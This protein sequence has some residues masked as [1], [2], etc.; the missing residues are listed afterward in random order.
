MPNSYFSWPS[1]PLAGWA[2]A[3]LGL[4][5][6]PAPAQHLSPQPAPAETQAPE[7][8][9]GPTARR[10]QGTTA[11]PYTTALALNVAGTYT[12]L[13][14]GGTVI[15]TPNNDDANS[16]PQEIGFPFSY[17]GTTFS[18][19]VLNTNGFIKLGEAAPAANALNVLL[20]TTDANVL[21]PAS[22]V[23]L[24]GAADQ[25]ANPTEFRVATTGAAGS[26]VCTIQF[27]N[28]R[29]KPTGTGT[30]AIPAQMS[31]MQFQIR[32]YEG[33][34]TID[35]V[36]GTWTATAN[37][38]TGQPFRIGLKGNALSNGTTP[39]AADLAELSLVAKPSLSAWSTATFANTTVSGT[40]TFP[41]SHFVR[42][43]VLPD[44][45]RTY[46]FRA[47]LPATDAAVATIH[48]LG[49]LAVPNSLP[50]TVVAAVTNRGTAA[51]TNLPVTLTVSGA[52][53]FTSTKTITTLAAG[54]TAAV[55]FDAYPATLALGTNNL[56]VSVPDDAE[57]SNNTLTYTQQVTSN[58]LAYVDD[59][60]PMNPT[61]IGAADAMLAARYTV[62]QLSYLNEV[63]A[64]F[65]A[66]ANNTGG[67]RIVIY[68]AT[69][70]NN[71]PGNELYT[72]T[73]QNRTAAGG[74]ITVP[75]P[76]VPV[77]GSFFIAIREAATNVFLGYQ[78]ENPLR[79]NTF[80]FQVPGGAWTA[81]SSN[82]PLRLALDATL[83][84][85]PACPIP[86]AIT[87]GNV[88]ARSATIT[89]TASANATSFT[90]LYGPAGFNPATEGARVTSATSPIPLAGL[91]G[92]TR[93]DVYV[94]ANCGGTDKSI[95]LGPFTFRTPCDVPQLVTTFP[96]RENFDNV[97]AGTPLC[98]A[99]ILN[100]NNDNRTWRVA[101]T[102][103]NN[104]QTIQLAESG[105]NALLYEY[106]T[107]AGANADDWYFTAPLSLK[108]N[109]RYQLSF[110][111]R[112]FST[113][114]E[115]L[116]VKYGTGTT[117]AAQTN[118]LWQNDNITTQAYT[119]ANATSTPAVALMAPTA[120]GTYYVGFHVYSLA[121][122]FLLAL[123][124]VEITAA[125]VT[126]TSQ[127]LM[128]AVNFYPNPTAGQLTV[129]VRG[130]SARGGLQVE[131]TNLLG[132]RVHTATVRDNAENTLNLSHLAGGMY[133]VKVLAGNEYMVRNVVLA[134]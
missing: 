104:K 47:V 84:V 18:R 119:S 111:Y 134:K 61:G 51:L 37:T 106:S 124:N 123:D 12:D 48:T 113:L 81:L 80:Y 67:F 118:L 40:Q 65:V 133:T 7:S 38:P 28:L 34:N 63:K 103:T 109:M 86:V 92:N 31:T 2:L 56:S 20:N 128:R 4:I 68:D 110:R 52:N 43:T 120:D 8:V 88:Q 75:L 10:P 69:G 46:R 101:S 114:P 85:A 102:Y 3:A 121:D 71:T 66:N 116:E 117:A 33:S 50:H 29:D 49:K 27:K 70:A 41:A 83:G 95:L 62:S 93:Y 5:A 82:N 100:D 57:S 76:G 90:V 17:N 107:V 132:Q 53:T 73:V 98:E 87:I 13:G 127:A 11:M 24:E 25:A 35:F 78:V 72:S 26:R 108:A 32:L 77:N 19:F 1:L 58:A 30:T 125:A 15:S 36:Y 59:R 42:N 74:T 60:Q 130:A 54:A 14:T 89:F 112:T 129:D 45:G 94:Q 97:L 39:T 105:P 6:L 9:T 126:G 122:Q 91:V 131:V 79:V 99:T 55:T 96:Y 21:A 44:P 16:Q 22:G 23:D 115:R 64:T